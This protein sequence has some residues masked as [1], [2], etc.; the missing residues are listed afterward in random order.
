MMDF[1]K[2]IKILGLNP[3]FTQE[4]LKKAHRKLSVE[5]H[6][7]K[8]SGNE[9]MNE[10][11]AMINAARDYLHSYAKEERTTRTSFNIHEYATKKLKDLENIINYTTN[12]EITEKLFME[13]K[14]KINNIINVFRV[15]TIFAHTL[16][17]QDIDKLYTQSKLSI[18]V[19]LKKFKESFYKKYYI[20]E[21]EVKETL[22]YECNLF[23]FYNQL[24]NIEKKYSKESQIT[25]RLEKEIEKYQNYAG[26][27]RLKG[28][29]KLC[30]NNAIYNIKQNEFENIEEDI[31]KM[32]Q[33]ILGVFKTY[34]DQLQTINNLSQEVYATKNKS[35]EEKYEELK[36]NFE[37]GQSFYDIEKC[38]KQVQSLIEEHKI[39]MKK[40]SDFKKHEETIDKIYKLLLDRYYKELKK[41]NIVTEYNTIKKLNEL[42]KDVLKVLAKGCMEFKPLEYFDIFNN[43]NFTDI[44]SDKN[45]IKRAHGVLKRNKSN[46]YIKKTNKYMFDDSSFFY[47]DEVKMVMYKDSVVSRRAI[48]K[49]ELDTEYVSLEEVLESATFVGDYRIMNYTTSV[50]YLYEYGDRVI[51]YY[52]NKFSI[53]K[54]KKDM[55]EPLEATGKEDSFEKFEDKEYVYRMIEQQVKA[56]IER[57]RIIEDSFDKSK[58][59]D[60]PNFNTDDDIY[61]GIPKRGK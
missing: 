26:Y 47:L 34:H 10:K 43:I 16:T 12:T 7:D 56:K 27:E 51:Y 32:H 15:D 24:L 61:Y 11:Q 54:N 53:I 46:I 40:V 44:D 35:I 6:P 41:H 19:E 13:S 5:N 50:A 14:L 38:I 21:S 28:L 4:E 3:N 9:G 2:A 49:E 59:Y 1:D 57:Y 20:K 42:L 39:H 25:K 18:I 17:K 37:S 31:A 55:F 36:Q 60:T 29:V 52:D 48:T 58:I 23:E 30:R 45:I 33:E 22:N 8:H